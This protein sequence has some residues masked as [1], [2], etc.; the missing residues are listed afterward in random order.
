MFITVMS[1]DK[2]ISY[3]NV[4]RSHIFQSIAD[5]FLKIGLVLLTYLYVI[6]G[7]PF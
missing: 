4:I 1:T 3:Y 6:I 2:S 7:Y 5:K